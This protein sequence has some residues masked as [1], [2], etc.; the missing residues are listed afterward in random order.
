MRSQPETR[1][2]RHIPTVR[3]L[4]YKAW[5]AAV[6]FEDESGLQRLSPS[7]TELESPAKG[8]SGSVRQA[9][10]ALFASSHRANASVSASD[11]EVKEFELG[12]SLLPKL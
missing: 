5:T 11:W 10:D 9:T 7:R 3:R 1:R 4:A 2:Y 12:V 6:R 8:P